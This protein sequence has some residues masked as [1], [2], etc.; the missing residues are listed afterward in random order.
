MLIQEKKSI[1]RRNFI[2][3]INR[4]FGPITLLQVENKELSKEEI[5]EVVSKM[6]DEAKEK[7]SPVKGITLF[8]STDAGIGRYYRGLVSTFTLENMAEF[9]EEMW[10][11]MIRLES[12]FPTKPSDN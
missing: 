5:I 12:V 8:V 10:G 2:L 6:F 4:G 3:I 1:Q 7:G 9:T 11:K